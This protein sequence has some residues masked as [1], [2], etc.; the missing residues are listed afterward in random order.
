MTTAQTKGSTGLGAYLPDNGLPK[1]RASL[2]CE[3]TK[4]R[5]MCQLTFVML[6]PRLS[7]CENLVRQA[8]IW[9]LNV[10]SRTSYANLSTKCKEKTS[11]CIRENMAPKRLCA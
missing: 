11:P 2:K 8:S 5:R 4:K 9:L 1:C 7:M 6:F 10:W 3:S